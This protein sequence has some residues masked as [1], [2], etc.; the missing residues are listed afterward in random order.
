MSFSINPFL[1]MEL[2]NTVIYLFEIKIWDVK[3][4]SRELMLTLLME[5][6]Q[7]K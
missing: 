6:P 4:S 1:C 7:C 2:L 3:Q 5:G